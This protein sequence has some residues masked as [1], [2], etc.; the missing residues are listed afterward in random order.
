MGHRDIQALNRTSVRLKP[1]EFSVDLQQHRLVRL[2]RERKDR[3]VI[4]V[5]LYDI[6]ISLSSWDPLKVHLHH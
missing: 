5:F 6:F 2:S 3:R 4:M 1:V